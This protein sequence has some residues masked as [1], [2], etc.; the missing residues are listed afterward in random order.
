M[1][2]NEHSQYIESLLQQRLQEDD[3]KALSY[4]FATYYNILFRAGIRWSNDFHL[5]E[6]SIQEVFQDLWKYRHSVSDIVSFEAYLKTSLKN[7]VAKK[8][9]RKIN[10]FEDNID[11]FTFS[12]SSYEQILIEQEDSENSK[13]QI[14]K[15]LEE[16]SPR[17]KELIVLKYFDELTYKEISDKT[18]L[19]VDSIYKTLHEGIKKLKNLLISKQ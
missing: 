15:A 5:A 3:E 19:Q 1:S 17:Q 13:M 6:E 14:K 12:V 8:S 18:G 4:L 10:Y 2:K 7:K 11:H 9:K 16:L